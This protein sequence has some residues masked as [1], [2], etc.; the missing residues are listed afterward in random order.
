MTSL[1]LFQEKSLTSEDSAKGKIFIYNNII[2]SLYS[3]LSNSPGEGN[4]SIKIYNN[5]TDTSYTIHTG[6][7]V[8]IY[9]AIVSNNRLWICGKNIDT[10]IGFYAYSDFSNGQFQTITGWT[11]PPESDYIRKLFIIDDILHYIQISSGDGEYY[12]TMVSTLSSSLI[13]SDSYCTFKDLYYDG[14]DLYIVI[15]TVDPTDHL[16]YL[17]IFKQSNYS[18]STGL[19]GVSVI[20]LEDPS[21]NV[22][23]FDTSL[24]LGHVYL[25][26]AKAP[27]IDSNSS[28][29]VSNEVFL[30][31]LDTNTITS[32]F[33]FPYIYFQSVSYLYL[34][35]RNVFVGYLYQNVFTTLKYFLISLN[36]N[37]NLINNLIY[38]KPSSSNYLS[39][40]RK[41]EYVILDKYYYLLSEKKDSIQST[42]THVIQSKLEFVVYGNAAGGSDP[43]IYPL[44]SK[45]FDMLRASTSKWYSF[46]EM[47]DFK[48]KVKFVGLKAGVFF[49]KIMIKTRDVTSE[50]NKKGKK[51]NVEIDFNQKKIKGDVLEH[52]CHKGSLGIK[53]NNLVVNKKL[54]DK[55][56]SKKMDII[57]FHNLKYPLSLYV[58]MDFRYVHFRF[59]DKIPSESECSGLIV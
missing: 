54:A 15:E 40:D 25:I 56:D 23:F 9:D 27:F 34:N 29:V 1:N 47:D 8:E 6:K 13:Y 3:I 39:N 33:T 35:G 11:E 37:A 24:I 36:S 19:N 53:Y 42:E 46:L 51:K 48:M 59:E 5:Q 26:C 18:S 22:I 30:Y 21:K 16:T 38:I 2:Y 32:N 58:D 7:N 57:D 28:V 12:I 44:F 20:N 45:R 43:H 10:N 52:E 41:L 17:K 31:R 49:H 4:Q 55:F 14:D 50:G